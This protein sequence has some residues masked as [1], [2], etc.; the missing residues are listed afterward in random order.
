MAIFIEVLFDPRLQLPPLTYSPTV[1]AV[2]GEKLK[3]G[4]D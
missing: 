2:P 3:S 4:F 1:P